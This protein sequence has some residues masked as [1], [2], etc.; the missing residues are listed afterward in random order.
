MRLRGDAGGLCSRLFLQIGED[1]SAFGT[2][3]LADAVG[4]GAGVVQL[5][6]VF[7]ECSGGLSLGLFSFGDAT[8]DGL[9]TL[10]EKSSR[11]S[12]Q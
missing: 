1:L 2:G 9:G 3:F 8:F 6:L 5:L 7:L 11:T 10:C 12:G 4:F